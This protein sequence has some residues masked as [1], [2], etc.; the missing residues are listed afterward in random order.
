MWAEQYGTPVGADITYYSKYEDLFYHLDIDSPQDKIKD[1]IESAYARWDDLQGEIKNITDWA[2]D[3]QL[4][5]VKTLMTVSVRLFSV[6]HLKEWLSY[7]RISEI[8]AMNWTGIR[9]K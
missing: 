8:R 1:Y 7:G 6:L 4:G 2:E 5:M 3:M 9:Q